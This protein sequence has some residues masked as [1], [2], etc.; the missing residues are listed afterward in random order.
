MAIEK[1]KKLKMAADKAKRPSKQQGQAAK[2]VQQPRRP[3]AVSE[4]APGFQRVDEETLGY[5]HEVKEHFVTM[6]DAEER[7]LLVRQLF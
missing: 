5:F 7:A 2:V 4:A 3:E 1:P 6:E